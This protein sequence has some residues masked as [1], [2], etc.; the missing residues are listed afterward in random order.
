MADIRKV[1][2]TSVFDADLP[3]FDAELAAE[4]AGVFIRAVA[5]AEARHRDGHHVRRLAFQHFHRLDADQQRQRRI[6]TA[7]NSEHK[8]LRMNMFH[9][10]RKP[11]LLDFKR[12]FANRRTFRRP[13]RNERRTRQR[14]AQILRFRP[15]LNFDITILSF[16][17]KFGD[18]L[19]EFMIRLPHCIQSLCIDVRQ[20][21]LRITLEQFVLRQNDAILRDDGLSAADRVRRRFPNARRHIRIRDLATGTLGTNQIAR[22]F[23]RTDIIRLCGKADNQIGSL[24]GFFRTWRNRHLQL[25]AEFHTK[26]Q[27]GNATPRIEIIRAIRAAKFHVFSCKQGIC[28]FEMVPR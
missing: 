6:E 27:A 23:P 12:L 19:P 11:R 16:L 26:A 28:T 14:T 25:I 18:S 24:Q 15:F 3:Q 7:R 10:F 4:I 22:L 21:H 1:F 5:C 9:S 17:F 13:F 20:N 8:F 2:Q